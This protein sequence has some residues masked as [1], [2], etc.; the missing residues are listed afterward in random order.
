[1]PIE[2]F[3][4]EGQSEKLGYRT[5]KR[6]KG[7]QPGTKFPVGTIAPRQVN[8]DLVLGVVA[9]RK[10]ETMSFKWALRHV[11]FQIPVVREVYSAYLIGKSLNEN[12]DFVMQCTKA[13][14]KNGLVGL[15]KVL[16]RKVL[17][18]ELPSI[19]TNIIWSAIG[20]HI[21]PGMQRQSREILSKCIDN[22]TEEEIDYV[23]RF[24]EQN[25]KS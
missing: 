14:R 15:S 19:Q 5:R 8:V 4:S 16:G 24:L 1:M 20:K 9:P 18:Q 10:L 7:R 13:F 21:P 2:D 3:F 25:R 22:L 23:E 17:E 11:L 12:W 6:G